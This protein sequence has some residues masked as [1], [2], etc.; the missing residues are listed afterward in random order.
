MGVWVAYFPTRNTYM[1]VTMNTV[2]YD[3]ISILWPHGCHILRNYNKAYNSNCKILST[4]QLFQKMYPI[5]YSALLIFFTVLLRLARSCLAVKNPTTKPDRTGPGRVRRRVRV[6]GCVCADGNRAR[7]R[8][9][10]TAPVPFP[11]SP[12]GE[13]TEPSRPP[14]VNGRYTYRVFGWRA[15]RAGAGS[16]RS[17]E[18]LVWG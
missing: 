16:T 4:Y 14:S 3:T 9:R 5:Q 12:A 2:R 8:R 11:T 13:V 17:H 10:F 15:E 7:A 6:A 1:P 18:H